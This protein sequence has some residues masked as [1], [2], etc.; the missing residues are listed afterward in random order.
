MS[1]E[2]ELQ[3]VP[4]TGVSDASHI[5][6]SQDSDDEFHYPG[7]EPLDHPLAETAAPTTAHEVHDDAN[8]QVAEEEDDDEEEFR[9]PGAET[10]PAPASP[11]VQPEP[12][13]SPPFEPRVVSQEPSTLEPLPPRVQL[14]PSS[15]QLES[16]AKAATAGD[17]EELQTLFRNI[18][19]ETGCESF[20]LANDHAP[21][22]GLTAL[23]HAASR[24]YLAIVQWL[25][26][27]CG[28]MTDLEDKEGETAL[29]KASLNGH[30][31][32]L[33]YLLSLEIEK[34]DV[35]AQDADGWTALHNACSKGYLD[36]VRFL[37]E[38]A[39]AADIPPHDAEAGIRG[40][41]RKSKGGWTPL[42]NAASKGHLPVV[43]YLLTKQNAD[44]L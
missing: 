10:P 20:V 14:G 19:E 15:A 26:E 39:G 13:T 40:V 5:D 41:D 11:T 21:R 24:G 32:V 33:K 16:V 1:H 35:H 36:I 8:T 6:S 25:V 9:Y 30:I 17:L 22:T 4:A 28:A 3:V 7:A 31:S 42:M 38:N 29:H 43:R 37:C 18:I 23:H 12:I 34:A 27:N 2:R 44:P